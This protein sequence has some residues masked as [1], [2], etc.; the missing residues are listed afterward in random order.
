VNEKVGRSIQVARR[1]LDQGVLGNEVE[2]RRRARE[3]AE[4][5]LDALAHH[6]EVLG[7]VGDGGAY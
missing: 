7:D 6:I 3:Q 5:R 4:E 1:W 2:I